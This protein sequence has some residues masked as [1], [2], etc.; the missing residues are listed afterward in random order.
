MKELKGRIMK[1]NVIEGEN[2]F[3]CLKRKKKRKTKL[4]DL[5][6]S[7]KNRRIKYIS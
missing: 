5:S 2:S 3:E 4:F 7:Y 6:C 1:I